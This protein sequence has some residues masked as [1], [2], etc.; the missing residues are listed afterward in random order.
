MISEFRYH[1]ISINLRNLYIMAQRPWIHIINTF[2]ANTR[3]SNRKM[4][5]LVTDTYAKLSVGVADADILLLRNLLEPHYIA[6]RQ[7]SMD[8]DVVAGNR[9][10]GTLAFEQVMDSVPMEVRKWESGVR[11]VYY[12]DTPEERAIFPN[13]RNPFLK[14]TYEERL[15]AIGALKQKLNT[16]PALASTHAL[17]QSFYTMAM[18]TRLAQQQDEGS[19][20]QISDLREQQRVLVADTLYGVLGSLMFKYRSS[21]E[22]IDNYFDLT[23]LRSKGEGTKPTN[24]KGVVTHRN[25]S[26]P[27]FNVE[28]TLIH[29]DGELTTT[30]DVTGKFAFNN[31]EIDQ[32]EDLTVRFRLAGFLEHLEDFTL[33]LG[34]SQKLDMSLNPLPAPPL[35]PMP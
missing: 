8:Y 29:P 5:S 30:T 9:E 32:A 11:A 33:V 24:L 26:T 15:S 35:P 25:T 23:L 18:G 6:Y 2:E 10:G 14:G 20:A 4:L 27:L 16:I 34:E 31:L 1:H 12:E 28:V 7:V 22:H 19:L 21:R 13:K 3:G 17:V